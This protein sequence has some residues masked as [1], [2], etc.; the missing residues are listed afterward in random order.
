MTL[1]SAAPWH[2]ATFDH[3]LHERLPELLAAR[4]PVVGYSVASTSTYTCSV[5]VSLATDA[6]D[7]AVVY[8]DVLQPDEHGIWMLDGQRFV[9]VPIADHEELATAEVRCAGEQIYDFIEEH[10]GEPPRD[11]PWDEALLRAWLPLDSWIR[12]FFAQ[13]SPHPYLAHTAQYL[14]WVNWLATHTHLRRVLIRDRQ[15]VIAPGQLGRTCPFET[16]E[17]PNIGRILV[18]ATGAEIRDGRLQIVDDRPEATLGLEAAMIP[19]LEHND[20]ARLLM[21]T[22][23]LRQWLPPS[24]PE[25]AL[26]QTGNEPDA[27]DFWC[28][29]N[30]LTAFV[31]WGADS[32]ED[33]IVIS[34]SCARRLDYPAAVEPGDKLSTRHG[35]KGVV[36]RILPDDEMPL[37][38]DG[39]PVELVYDFINAHRRM[40]FGQVREAIMSRIARAEGTP[41]IVPPFHAPSEHELRE[42]LV[43]A[44]LPAD[45]ME[46]LTFGRGGAPLDRPSTAGWVYWGRLLHMASNKIRAQVGGTGNLQPDQRPSWEEYAEGQFQGELEYYALRDASAF[47]MI[48]EQFNTRALERADADTLA[49]RVAAGALQQA[50]PP[51]PRFAELVRRL[52]SAGIAVDWEGDRLAFRLAPPTGIAL[53]L[54]RPVTHPWLRTQKLSEVG[55]WEGLPEYAALVEANARLERVQAS[56]APQSLAEQAFA[57]LENRVKAFCDALL[58]AEQVRFGARVLFS[59]RAVLAP[60][61]GLRLDQV[62]L[63]ADIAWTL[64][65]PQVQRE[66]GDAQAVSARSER[67]TN[68]LDDVMARAWVVIHRAP[69][70]TPTAF[71]AF[72]PVRTTDRVIRLHPLACTLLNADF[73]G[74]QAAV[75]LPLSEATQREAGQR[76]SLAGHLTRNPDLLPLVLPAFDALWGLAELSR[77]P[78]GPA[79]IARLVGR[80][81]AA[82]QGVVT[83]DTLAEALRDMFQRDGIEQVLQTLDRL[84]RRGFEVAQTS[85]A[86][87]S[88]FVGAT[89][90]R[91]PA[92]DTGDGEAWEVYAEEL[93]ERIVTRSDLDD[94]DL[95]PQLLAIKSGVRGDVRQ[96]LPLLGPR[97]MVKDAR[98]EPVVVRHGYRDGLLPEEIFAVAAGER[99]GLARIALDWERTQVGQRLRGTGEP[100]NLTVLARAMRSKHPGIV[101]A[102]AA[103][104]G[105]S[106]PLHD[107][108]SRRFV[109]LV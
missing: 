36:S 107:P 7:I 77:R 21:G 12:A 95:G 63:A 51:S 56:H 41:A 105:E 109:G 31:S 72:H 85:G 50:P 71:L 4:L 99:E 86:S 40:H 9:V 58:G 5:T 84:A 32:Y 60:G 80:D 48:G 18:I 94:P 103:A 23:M 34:E 28:G 102:R 61:A 15:R 91:P 81:V 83:W 92:P 106:D 88:P 13:E 35:A 79:E 65:G 29:R 53:T 98:G 82:P 47:E 89:L 11:L 87:I 22:N 54:A 76:L 57:R 62:G 25:P 30:L 69:S 24:D 3:M 104:T 64:F 78:D 38:A 8:R 90:E 6:G 46:T 55:A 39:T 44:G 74:D 20:P 59:G 33:G 52:A 27:P 45:G 1:N 10:L 14:D 93:A 37:L 16:P 100:H 108:D 70:L 17:G 2:K 43:A 67:A 75:F 42:R 66:L 26:V 96:F 49:A 101:F 73:D 97:G 68:V 19:F